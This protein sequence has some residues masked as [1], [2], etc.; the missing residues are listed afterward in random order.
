MFQQ[1]RNSSGPGRQPSFIVLTGD[2][3]VDPCDIPGSQS[4]SGSSRSRSPTAQECVDAVDPARRADEL[5]RVAK[6]LAQSPVKTIYLAAGNNDIA[7]ED[8]GEVS[9]AYFNQFIDDLQKRLDESNTGVKL[10]NLTSCYA[11]TGTCYAD[12]GGRYRLIGFPSY[13]FKNRGP[14]SIH[15]EKQL[16]QFEVFRSLLDQAQSAHKRVLVLEH[17]PNLDDPFVLAQDRYDARTPEP[18]DDS[19]PKNSRA[20]W[21]AWNVS[22][23]LLQGWKE[24]VQSQTIVAVL[25]GHFH[26]SHEEVYRRPYSWSTPV[27]PIESRKLFVA[28]PLAVKNQDTSPVQARGYSL[29]TLQS[30]RLHEVLYWYDSATGQFA[31]QGPPKSRDRSRD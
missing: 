28:P 20:P 11:G 15:D 13:S 23:K 12:V 22:T 21:S 18:N 27:D 31:A 1:L 16:K 24:A 3:N 19:D 26:D 30:N 2:L 7:N 14:G 8:P 6:A 9:L 4:S 5:S 17:I 29:I 10:H 25:A